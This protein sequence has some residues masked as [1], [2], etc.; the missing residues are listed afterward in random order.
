MATLIAFYDANVLYP[1]EL[2]NFLMHLA[3]TAR[4]AAFSG[5]FRIETSTVS[6]A[7]TGDGYAVI[8][9][10]PPAAGDLPALDEI[11]RQSPGEIRIV[12]ED[13]AVKIY[14]PWRTL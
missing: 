9:I 12:V 5:P 2:R 6:S 4:D 1:A 10:T 7:D 3:L 13:G 14:L 11:V 8:S